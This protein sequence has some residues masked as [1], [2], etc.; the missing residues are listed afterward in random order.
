MNEITK[1]ALTLYHPPFRYVHGYIYDAKD[2]MVADGVLKDTDAAL[3]VRGWG[4]ISY[5]QY[6][7]QLQD[8]VGVLIAQAM[9][10]F[11]KKH[12]PEAVK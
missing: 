10:E 2:N 8:T 11:W 7:E 12:L 6:P 4:R 9:T 5:M 3:R 1:V